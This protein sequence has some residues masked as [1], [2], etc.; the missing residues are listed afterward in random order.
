MGRSGGGDR[1][2]E[3][4]GRE[5]RRQQPPDASRSEMGDRCHATTVGPDRANH[6][7]ARWEIPERRALRELPGSSQ[8]ALARRAEAR[9]MSTTSLPLPAARRA[10]A[11]SLARR[12]PRAR[13]PARARGRPLPLGARPQRLRQRV[14][15]RRRALDEHEL[16]R[17]PL[18]LLR[19]RRRDDGRQA[20]ARALGSS[21]V[22]ARVRVQL[23]E[24]PRPAGAD[25]RR[26]GRPD[27]RHDP[28]ALR[29]RRRLRRRPRA[30]AHAGHRRDRAPQQPRRAARAVLHRRALVPRQRP[31]G[32]AHALARARGRRRRPRLRGEDGGGAARRARHRRR[33]GVGGAARARQG[34]CSPAARR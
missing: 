12:P 16:A 13:R 7:G 11:L 14:L 23:M 18:R 27:L 3:R 2:R 19:H 25:G 10:R 8:P 33:V 9:R 20:A 21:A 5:D 29:P 32:R 26:D 28:P 15:Q 22:R 4:G 1:R 24:H 31:R 34:R 17:L 6:L 30:R